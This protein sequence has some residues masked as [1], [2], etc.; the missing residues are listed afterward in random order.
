MDQASLRH[1][2]IIIDNLL[3]QDKKTMEELLSKKTF[4]LKSTSYNEN[5]AI[6][7]NH[8]E[9]D[10]LKKWKWIFLLTF[11]PKFLLYL[12]VYSRQKIKSMNNVQCF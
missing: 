6:Q 12:L 8:V 9:N 2:K 1:W 3:T 4:N 7:K 11:Q 10:W 5:V